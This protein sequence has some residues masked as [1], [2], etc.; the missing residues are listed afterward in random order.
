MIS[1]CENTKI[2]LYDSNA[3]LTSTDNN[4]DAHAQCLLKTLDNHQS[5]S[6]HSLDLNPFQ[7]NL[8]ASGAGQSEIFI[9]DLNNPSQPMCPGTKQ[10]P[11]DDVQCVAWNN[12]VQH[13]L[14]S[15][16]SGRCVVWD[17][18][19]NESIIKISENMS[20][21]KAKLVAWHPDIATQLCLSS[22]DDHTPFMQLWDL[23]FSSSPVRV[24]EGH[25]RYHKNKN[26]L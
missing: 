2:Y 3:L 19:K 17:L 20:K 6:I 26:L 18:R 5:G 11:L 21:L 1:G 15:T 25:Q 7:S 16:S 22:D 24:L 13:I 10:Q 23:R 8:L 12:Q 9:W 14:A 4:I